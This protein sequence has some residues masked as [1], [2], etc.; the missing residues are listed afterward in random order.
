MKMEYIPSKYSSKS[1]ITL[2]IFIDKATPSQNFIQG[3]TL[4]YEKLIYIHVFS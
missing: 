2:L 1:H 4:C 3:N